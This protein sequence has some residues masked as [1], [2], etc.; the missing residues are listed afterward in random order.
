VDGFEDRIMTS[1]ASRLATVQREIENLY[2]L[3]DPDPESR[4][5]H[6]KR[7][8][9]AFKLELDRVQK[10]W[11]EV[12][13][14]ADAVEGI[15]EVYSLAISLRADFRRVEDSY[16]EADRHLRQS[17]ISEQH[18]RGD[19]VD[20]LLD[21]HD[22]LLETPEGKVFHGFHEQL[23][24]S[25]ELDHMKQRLRNILKNPAVTDALTSQQQ[26]DL[27]WLIAGLVKESRSVIQARARSE[28]D[29]KSFLKTGL[30]SEH[31]RVGQ[32]LND[33]FEVA[34]EMDWQ[35]NK[36]RRVPAPLPPAG[37]SAGNLPLVE[38]LR[39]KSIEEEGHSVIELIDKRIDL[40]DIEEDFWEAF[41]ALDHRDLF[42]KTLQL[43]TKTNTTMSLAELNHHLPPT[44]DL[45][46]LTY[47]LTMAR[48][49]G[50]P[51]HA[52]TEPLELMDRNGQRL[53]FMV[54]KIE[55]TATALR[56]IDWEL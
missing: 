43:L 1:T 19:I 55:L 37:I 26:S 40:N 45:E 24:R 20:K 16:R 46:T 48:A 41:D 18:N 17:I 15:R 14:G 54:P 25:A 33:I 8:I 51:V 44:H 50:A 38:R 31:H 35:R 4:S 23:N 3:L 11:V 52:E 28:H 47:W 2:T 10:G 6:L 32:L 12:L 30:A 22:S 56:K 21:S 39:F 53:R 34:M 42:E 7:K 9:E 29:V 5:E 49:A 27:R 13:E 36:I